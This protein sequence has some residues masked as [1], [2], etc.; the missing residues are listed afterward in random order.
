MLRDI[1][2]LQVHNSMPSLSKRPKFCFFHI[3]RFI[4]LS[5]N[6]ADFDDLSRKQI[7]IYRHLNP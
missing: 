7:L 6:V 4:I 5:F 2:V 3:E 1:D